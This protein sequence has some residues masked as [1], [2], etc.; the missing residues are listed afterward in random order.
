MNLSLRRFQCD[1]LNF[2]KYMYLFI[3]KY[4]HST[5][6]SRGCPKGHRV[7]FNFCVDE[8]VMK[9]NFEQLFQN[10]AKW[11]TAEQNGYQQVIN[12]TIWTSS[13]WPMI[14]LQFPDT[15]WE[16]QLQCWHKSTNTC[17][18]VKLCMG[19]WLL[20][21]AEPFPAFVSTSRGNKSII[22]RQKS[23]ANWGRRSNVKL[24]WP[25][26]SGF[27]AVTRSSNLESAIPNLEPAINP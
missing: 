26:M 8:L 27:L 21:N 24:F 22:F 11:R 9:T 2:M 4:I 15:Q 17:N 6:I 5:W 16:I 3:Y 20:P 10:F 18:N 7:H 13:K 14:T 12:L 25:P 1:I 23:A 19:A